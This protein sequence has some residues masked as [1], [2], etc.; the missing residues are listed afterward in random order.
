MK[1]T[2]TGTPDGAS[3][4]VPTPDLEPEITEVALISDWKEYGDVVD[5]QLD[6]VEPGDTVMIGVRFKVVCSGER[7]IRW[8]SVVVVEN[9]EG[10]A[11]ASRSRENEEFDNSC[12][13]GDRLAEWE[14]AFELRYNNEFGTE[15]PVGN[16]EAQARIDDYYGEETVSKTEDFTVR[17]EN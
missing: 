3:D 12:G 7:E 16:Y 10:D 14:G 11:V 8:R 4:P 6:S 2:P 13:E 17:E 1:P 5:N 15:W 9:S